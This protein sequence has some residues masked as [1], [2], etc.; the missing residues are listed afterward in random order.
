[1]EQK[2]NFKLRLAFEAIEMIHFALNNI[3]R[4]F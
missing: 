1:M 2:L 4:R 3:E